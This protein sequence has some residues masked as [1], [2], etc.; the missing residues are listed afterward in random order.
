MIVHN[1]SEINCYNFSKWE[2]E[3][4]WS[5]SYKCNLLTPFEITK[6]PAFFMVSGNCKRELV[7]IGLR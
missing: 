6:I 5:I 7:S 3:N 1:N 4:R 2:L